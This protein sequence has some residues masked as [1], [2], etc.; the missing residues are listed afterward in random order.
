V[1]EAVKRLRGDPMMGERCQACGHELPD[2]EWTF[3][4]DDR[5][6][7]VHRRVLRGTEL[8]ALLPALDDWTDDWAIVE[9]G[10]V[11][12]P[13][14]QILHADYVDLDDPE[15]CKPRRFYSVSPCTFG[16]RSR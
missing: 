9:D 1:S 2:G 8:R 4:F 11:G 12:Q 13:S 3:Y 14:R 16:S 7:T 15:A 10:D 6:H 5:P